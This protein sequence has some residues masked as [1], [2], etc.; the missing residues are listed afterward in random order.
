MITV[1]WDPVLKNTVILQYSDP[2]NSWDEYRQAVATAY[3]MALS[4]SGKVNFIHNAGHTKMPSGNALA[5]VRATIRS[6]PANL[7]LVL[8][9]V[10]NV[11]ARRVLETIV[12]VILRS[13]VRFVESFEEARHIAMAAENVAVQQH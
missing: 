3:E 12:R 13:R 10:D 2:V 11:A 9:V 8:M 7:G 5:E 4:Q 1:N 6:A